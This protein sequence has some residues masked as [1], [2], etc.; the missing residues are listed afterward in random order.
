MT[1]SQPSDP[2][3]RWL[4]VGAAR[5]AFTDEGAGAASVL[6]VP[7][8]PGSGRDYRWLAPLLA[9]HL[10]VVR[11]DPPGFGA[12]ARERFHGLSTSDRARVV[13]ALIERLEI[14]PVVLVGHSA[15][16]AVVAHLA[17]YRPESVAACV[18]LAPSGPRPEDPRVVVRTVA[19]ALRLPG[20]RR[21]LAPGLRRAFA[22]QGF[23][24][25]LTDSERALSMLDAARL[26][27]AAHAAN[28]A[29]IGQ[30]TMVAWAHDDRAIPVR[31][32]REVQHLV[33]AGPRVSF[34]T[35]GHNIQKTHA[36]E[37]AE[38]IIGFARQQPLPADSR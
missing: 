29:A 21:I 26:D 16:A 31:T 2:P 27:P 22:A 33:P 23:P 19:R 37:L 38:Q 18:L 36:A 13:V 20:G 5:V 10:R 35:G 14:A 3:P 24:G 7:G 15:G 34:P 4:Q 1:L 9:P 8:L 25:Y 6:A 30:P 17:R 12:T 11:F 28:L 32:F